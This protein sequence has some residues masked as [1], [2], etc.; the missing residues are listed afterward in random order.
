MKIYQVIYIG[1][2]KNKSHRVTRYSILDFAQFEETRYN[3]QLAVLKEISIVLKFPNFWR[4]IAARIQPI[5]VA[6]VVTNFGNYATLVDIEN[7]VKLESNYRHLI[8]NELEDKIVYKSHHTDY[9][10]CKVSGHK[11]VIWRCITYDAYA[12]DESPV[13]LDC[14]LWCRYWPT[15]M[16]INER[17]KCIQNTRDKKNAYKKHIEDLENELKNID[18]PINGWKPANTN[19]RKKQIKRELAKLKNTK[20]KN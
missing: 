4:G 10:H 7:D 18:K 14:V 13:C 6:D 5:L 8:H 9:K 11:S 15:R 12:Y 2:S 20:R 17:K 19:S 3:E 16:F 1:M